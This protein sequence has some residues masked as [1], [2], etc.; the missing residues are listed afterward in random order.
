MAGLTPMMQQYLSVKDRYPDAILFYRLGDF[1][2]MFF[3]DAKLVSRLLDLTLTGRDCGL[4]ERAPMCGVPYHAAE[5]YLCRLV[6]MG[7]K[8][9]ICEQM[10]DP[11]ASKGLVEREVVRVVT[12]GTVTEQALLEEKKSRYLL[13]LCASQKRMGLA[14]ADVTTGEFAVYELEDAPNTL[15]DEA[16]AIAPAEI[17]ADEAAM[18]LCEGMKLPVSPALYA[19]NAFQSANAK[20]C[21]LAH[22]QA[23]DLAALGLSDMPLAVR[24][25]GGLLS[26][27]EETQKN[28][29]SHMRAL[30]VHVRECELAM[31]RV[32]RRNLELTQTLSGRKGKGTLLHLLDRTA[33]AMGG[34]LLRHWIE[35][36][37]AR[38]TDIE[39]RHGAVE[40]LVEDYTLGQA[41]QG[42]LQGMSDI[43]RLMSKI[44]YGTIHGRDCLALGDTFGRVPEIARLLQPVQAPLVRQLREALDPLP[45]LC[46]LIARMIDP[47]APIT[48]TDG[49]VI[50]DGYNAE[51]DGYR[52]AARDGKQWI[53]DVEAREREETGIKNLKVGY[54]RVFGYYLEVTKSNYNLVPY[55]Y[56]RRQTLANCER[57][58]TPELQEIEQKIVGSEEKAFR[59]EQQLFAALRDWLGEHMERMQ[60]TAQALKQLDALC[61]LALT[62][63]EHGYVRPSM[64]EDGVIDIRDGRHPVVETTLTDELFVPNDTLLDCGDNRMQIIT[65]PNMAGKSTYMRQVA[66]IVLMAHV[67]SFVPAREANICLVDR[68]YTRVGASDDLSA[69]QSTFMVEMTELSNIVRNATSKSLLILDE[70]GRGTSTFDG[71]SIA[72]AVVEY[73]ADPRNI[74]AKTL[75]AT[76]YHELSE[77]EGKLPGVVNYN[78]RVKE[79]ESGILFLRKIARGGADKSFGIHVAQLA[80]LPRPILL[81]ANEILARIEANDTRQRSIGQNILEENR[82]E[83]KRQLDFEEI[84]KAALIE[85]L[86]TLEVM[87]MTPMEALNLLFRLREQAR[88]V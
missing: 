36:P 52:S 26:Y 57:Y 48:L 33:T 17:V 9:A 77:L 11:A 49:G 88:Q 84:G 80:G 63:Q 75:F 24:A 79:R 10:T 59:L 2:E 42:L 44:A 82:K 58:I 27:L 3:E 86:R 28:A 12:P 31:D 66:L 19:T 78:V 50:R 68:L 1:Y 5:G 71:L 22:F 4:E 38:R 23:Q 20:K 35:H 29:M 70:I 6:E 16:A 34:R 83:K 13:S 61:S 85:Q 46:A 87:E 60:R 73:I 30:R 15:G 37:L 62:S 55:R 53:A 40:A 54:N 8:V 18:R 64:N 43:E 72:W 81:R 65:G 74:G 51:L 56:H 47:E 21:V 67:G 41:L 76:H 14:F 7:Y 32:A 69:G 45:E 25:A 39:A